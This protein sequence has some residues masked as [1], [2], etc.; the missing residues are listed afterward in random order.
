MGSVPLLNRQAESGSPAESNGARKDSP[1]SG[2]LSSDYPGNGSPLEKK[3][4]G[5][6]CG[7]RDLLQFNDPIPD[8]TYEEACA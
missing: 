2:A 6:N 4:A 8:E 7:A 3:S 5:N 1:R